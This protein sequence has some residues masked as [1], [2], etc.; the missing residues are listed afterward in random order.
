L[1]GVAF[2]MAIDTLTVIAPTDEI[3]RS[4]VALARIGVDPLTAV[5]LANAQAVEADVFLSTDAERSQR[6]A[7]LGFTVLG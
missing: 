1:T 4:A 2:A 7:N 6:A 3:H 5:H